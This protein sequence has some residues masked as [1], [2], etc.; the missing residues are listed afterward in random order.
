MH[1]GGS[2]VNLQNA[3]DV[4]D[5]NEKRREASLQIQIEIFDKA[6]EYNLSQ[7]IYNLYR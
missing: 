7:G 5:K 3:D 2:I 1:Q 6:M 4:I